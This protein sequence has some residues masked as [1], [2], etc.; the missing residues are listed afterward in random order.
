MAAATATEP[1]PEPEPASAAG[2][3]AVDEEIV[4]PKT[5]SK[6]EFQFQDSNRGKAFHVTDGEDRS[7]PSGADED[8]VA[9]LQTKYAHYIITGG[10]DYKAPC[11]KMGPVTLWHAWTVLKTSNDHFIR[12]ENTG[13]DRGNFENSDG[14][15]SD[16]EKHGTNC[17][18]V[19]MLGED[20]SS[21]MLFDGDDSK[22]K[23]FREWTLTGKQVNFAQLLMP[24]YEASKRKFDMCSQSDD[25]QAFIYTIHLFLR[26]AG[27]KHV[28]TT[29]PR[30][31]QRMA[32]SGLA[33]WV[34]R[35]YKK[36]MTRRAAA[37]DYDSDDAPKKETKSPCCIL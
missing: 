27:A 18:M 15:I 10:T 16:Y 25:C 34:G 29:G 13:S 32:N 30:D 4:V 8:F 5:N 26:V 24:M 1:E 35:F 12:I 37:D 28:V 36:M 22:T 33:R 6:T 2:S 9:T 14:D 11:G 7:S 19:G 3:N 31:L 23:V 20:T 17:I 21:A